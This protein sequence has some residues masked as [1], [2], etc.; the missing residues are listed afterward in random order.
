MCKQHNCITLNPF[1]NETKLTESVHYTLDLALS[2]VIYL[3]A[4]TYRVA[5]FQWVQRQGPPLQ[6]QDLKDILQYHKAQPLPL[7]T[8]HNSQEVHTLHKVLDINN[9]DPHTLHKDLHTQHKDLHTHLDR[10]THLRGL[11]IPKQEVV[12]IHLTT[13]AKGKA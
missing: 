6:V 7:G 12:L 10:P 2:V 8:Y 9:R 3:S 1:L 13:Q 5:E 4:C 11:V